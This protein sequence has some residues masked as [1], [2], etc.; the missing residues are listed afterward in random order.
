VVSVALAALI[1]DPAAPAAVP[2]TVALCLLSVV[3]LVGSLTRRERVVV[4]SPTAIWL[5]F[6]GWSALSLLWGD[7]TA[8]GLSTLAAW[9]AAGGLMLALH[10]LE[11]PRRVEL[12]RWAALTVG[13]AAAAAAA[14]QWLLG[15]RGIG[16]HGGQGNPN[17]LGLLLVVTLPICVELLLGRGRRALLL[18]PVAL[19]LA[20]LVLSGSR[21]AWLALAVTG[22]VAVVCHGR[23][24]LLRVGLAGAALALILVLILAARAGTPVREA[25]GG[26]LQIWRCAAGAALTSAP[27]GAG[28]GGFGHVFLEEQGEVLSA[29]SPKEAARR[30]ENA[31]TAHNGYLQAAVETGPV[32]LLLL[33]MALA[34]AVKRGRRS[35]PAGA[36]ATV[37]LALTALGDSPLRQPAV[38]IM[39]AVVLP[40]LSSEES[41]RAPGVLSA[42]PTRAVALVLV[43]GL[44]V[45]ATARWLGFRLAAPARDAVL[46]ERRA[47]LQRASR[48]DPW[49]GAL[50]LQLG[51]SYLEQGRPAEA[52]VE[53]ER[54]E[55]RL[56]NVGTH[57]AMGNALLGLGRV[58]PAID[59]YR[60]A[61]AWHPGLFR[62]RANL[63]EALRRKG[64]LDEAARHLRVARSLYPGHPRLPMLERKLNRSRIETESEDLSGD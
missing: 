43:A 1:Y 33:V 36:W 63:A 58:Q 4:G 16:V 13:S 57:V 14:V 39:I 48:V 11:R 52:L 40:A 45:P 15:A 35:W 62:A 59:A 26:R 49:S 19:Q 22:A 21:V 53:L 37:A 41:V 32:G 34:L 20:G 28:L 55:R 38:L 64:E 51:L 42:W 12:S 29:L 6:C 31:T 24:T 30:F 61:L 9:S 5:A 54:S 8:G 60:K 56:A 47:I 46:V 2:K 3:L 27:L 7:H 25:W 50:G 18:L 23:G 17:W 44:L 10:R